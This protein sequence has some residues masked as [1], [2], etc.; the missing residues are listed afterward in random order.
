MHNEWLVA[1][2]RLGARRMQ[3]WAV[4][5]RFA[6]SEV[7]NIRAGPLFPIPANI[8]LAFRPRVSIGG[9]RGAV[10][11]DAAVARRREAPVG[12]D[13]S[14]Y[15]TIARAVLVALRRE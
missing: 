13:G 1:G 12:V 8:A 5:G 4:P 6:L 15:C 11:H 9:G 3:V 14:V 10:V 7:G 2:D